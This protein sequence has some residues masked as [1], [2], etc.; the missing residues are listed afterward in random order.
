MKKFF[1]TLCLLISGTILHAATETVNDIEWTY[2]VVNGEATIGTGFRS[3]AIPSSTNGAISIPA[4][5]GGYPVTSIGNYTFS[6]CR[7]L[8]SVTIPDSVTSIGSY[9]FFYCSNLTS[10]TIPSSVTSIGDN[11]F[12]GCSS[13][14]SVTIPEGVTSIGN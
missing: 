11:A 4:S 7:N 6:S 5:L 9:A 13:L 12:Y 2:Q 3:S 1:L 14:P 10:V 8:T